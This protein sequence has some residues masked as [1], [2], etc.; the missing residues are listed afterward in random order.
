MATPTDRFFYQKHEMLAIANAQGFQ[1]SDGLFEDWK[2]KG[3][4]VLQ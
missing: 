1:V 4:L 2:E 3:L